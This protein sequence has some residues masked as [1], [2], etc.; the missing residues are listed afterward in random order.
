MIIDQPDQKGVTRMLLRLSDLRKSDPAFAAI[1]LDYFRE[2]WE[3]VRLGEFE[4]PDE[5]FAEISRRRSYTRPLP[6]DKTISTVHKAKGLE[7]DSVL[8]LP[9]DAKHFGDSPASRCLLYV[10]MSRAKRSLTFVVSRQNPSPLVA[11]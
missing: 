1:K 11:L 2:F 9:C 7:C 3:A 8:I 6:P 5:A 10:A 4:N